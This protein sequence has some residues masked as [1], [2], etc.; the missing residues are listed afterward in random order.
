[1]VKILVNHLVASGSV[2][3]TILKVSEL[4]SNSGAI[5][6]KIANNPQYPS[7]MHFCRRKQFEIVFICHNGKID[8]LKRK[9]LE[10]TKHI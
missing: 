1:M 5:L 10:K 9:K 8:E 3:Q 6:K 2:M 4:Y 7:S